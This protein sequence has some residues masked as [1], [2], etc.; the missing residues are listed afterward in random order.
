MGATAGMNAN[1]NVRQAAKSLS[2]FADAAEYPEVRF[3]VRD[4]RNPI[5][6]S[7]T[8]AL[9]TWTMFRKW[10]EEQRIRALGLQTRICGRTHVTKRSWLA[11]FPSLAGGCPTCS[12]IVCNQL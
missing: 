7:R 12:M 5:P 2:F 10:R 6:T 8:R 1:A 3:P 9:D 4:K 11:F